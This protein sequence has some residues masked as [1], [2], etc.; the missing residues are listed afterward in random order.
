MPIVAVGLILIAAVLHAV[1]NFLI[2]SSRDVVAF[3]WW[4]VAIGTVGYGCWLLAGPGI[5]LSPGSVPYFLISTAAEFGYFLSLVRGYAHGDLSLV[6]PISRGS[7]PLFLAAWSALFL[8]ERLPSAGYAGIAIAV[9]GICLTS[10]TPQEAGTFRFGDLLGS[11]RRPAALWAVA[12][13]IFISV[14]SLTD[15]LAVASTPP[16]V[17]NFWVY[18]G[19]AILWSVVVWKPSR[20]VGNISMLKSNPLRIL[21]AAAATV[22]AYS[23][24]LIALTMTSA[25]YVV[26]GR[27]LSV[28]VGAL[29]GTVV[30]KEHFGRLR[31]TG[32]LLTVVGLTVMAL[33]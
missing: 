25:S 1:Y 22:G 14:Y 20:A 23:A 4:T 28:V 11:F 33:S 5:F 12:S 15:K 27:G 32:A 29:L 7:P 9:S 8:S 10:L 3:F 30:L 18:A 21:L 24:V 31:I 19:N 13:G 16:L 2:K 6:Y 17:Y 26:A